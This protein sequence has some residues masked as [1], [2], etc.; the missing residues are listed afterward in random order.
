MVSGLSWV[1]LTISI[2]MFDPPHKEVK[3]AITSVFKAYIKVFMITCDNEVTAKAI[4]KNI[5]LMNENEALP[6]VVKGGDLQSMTDE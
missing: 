5:G 4:S 3:E 2:T 1:L 6:I